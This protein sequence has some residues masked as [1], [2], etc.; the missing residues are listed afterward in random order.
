MTALSIPSNRWVARC[1]VI[2]TI[3]SGGLA[4]G[5]TTAAE[6]SD[7]E[8]A[9]GL[10]NMLRSA[11]TVISVNQKRIND[12]SIGDKSLTGQAVLGEAISNFRKSTGQDPLKVDPKSRYGKLLAAQMSAIVKVMAAQQTSINRLGIGFKGFVPATFARL[13]NEDFGGRMAKQAEVKVTALPEQVRNRKALPDQWEA[14]SI[15]TQ[16]LSPDWTRGK[17]YATT[18][19]NRGRRAFRVLVPEYYGKGCLSCHGEPKDTMDIT[20]YPKEGGQ[21]G[22]LGGVISVTLYQ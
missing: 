19:K 11:R 5:S 12:S 20:G 10:A 18:A 21:L 9:M 16:L 22:Q 14:E 3:V 15:R 17:V 8:I 7:L 13:V 4:I 1:V 6:T 2:V